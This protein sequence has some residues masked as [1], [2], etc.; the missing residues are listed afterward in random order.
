MH[1]FFAAPEIIR[2]TTGF[3]SCSSSGPPHL[4]KSKLA[5]PLSKLGRTELLELRLRLARCSDGSDGFKPLDL[6]N[7][8]RTSVKETT[9]VSRPDRL[10]PGSAAAG[11]DAEN[12]GLA[13]GDCGTEVVLEFWG[14]RIVGVM[15][16]VP[17]APP[18]AP[19]PA[20]IPWPEAFDEELAESVG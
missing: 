7:K 4:L 1:P 16:P 2:T 11:T 10:A 15:L 5:L 3:P 18:P 13:R 19:P 20:V 9:P 6:A 8:L 17:A 12:P 14:I